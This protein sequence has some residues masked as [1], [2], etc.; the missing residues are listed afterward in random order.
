MSVLAMKHVILSLI[1]QGY[2][3]RGLYAALFGVLIVLLLLLAV[4]D[5]N[6][7]PLKGKQRWNVSVNYSKELAARAVDSNLKTR[8]SSYAPMT[9]G[10]FFQVD[11]G[12]P[13]TMNGLLLQVDQHEKKGQPSRWTLKGSLNGKDWYTLETRPGLT[14]RGMLVMPFKAVQA[15]YIQ[16]VQTSI[17]AIPSPW[18][19]YE[20]DIL[21]PVVPWQFSRA[22]FLNV[23]VG[24]TLLILAMVLF[25]GRQRSMALVI[26]MIAILLLGW[27]VRVYGVSAYE[28]SEHERRF[29]QRLA[30]DRYTHG[31][32]LGTYVTTFGSGAYWLYF[33]LVRL[34]YQFWQSPLAAFRV[35]SGMFSLGSIL[36]V[37]WVWD[38]FSQEKS[39]LLEAALLSALLAVSGWQVYLSRTGD[40]SG[41][42]LL[43]FLLYLLLAYAFLYKRG[44]V[45]LAVGLALLLCL[46]LFLHPVMGLAPIG[47]LLFGVWHLW[48][49]RYAPTFF[50]SPQ[51]QSFLFRHHAPRVAIYFLSALP[52]LVYWIVSLRYRFFHAPLSLEDL[53]R[54]LQNDFRQLLQAGGIKGTAAWLFWGLVLLGLLS[55]LRGREHREWFLVGQIGSCM[56]LLTPFL[57]DEQHA[58]AFS[59]LLLLLLWLPAVRGLLVTMAFLSV[60]Q[61]ARASLQIRFVLLTVILG[62]SLFFSVSSL[63]SDSSS[64]AGEMGRF[65]IY[66]QSR[67]LEPL[68]QQVMSDPV[69][70]HRSVMVEAQLVAAYKAEYDFEASVMRL[71]DLLRFAKQGIFYSYAFVSVDELER[72]PDRERFFGRHYVEAG[73]TSHVVFYRLRDEFCGL[74]ERYYARDLIAATGRN[75]KDELV[76]QRAVRVATSDDRPGQMV[77]GPFTRQCEAGDYV[78]RFRLRAMSLPERT[79]ATLKVLADRHEVFGVRELSG[80][81]FPDTDAY[82][83]FD[84][85]FYLDFAG[86]PAY[87]MKRL[88]FLVDFH[89]EAEVRFDL[90]ELIPAQRGVR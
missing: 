78:A 53:R 26:G 86:N 75:M 88:E 65:A 32:W 43:V 56:L 7:R 59:L 4:N 50:S 28:F 14:Y 64:E 6:W 9:S 2:F 8:W 51:V 23:I 10:M 84:I 87:Q 31:E 44:S 1:K 66:R 12:K 55:I 52:G 5:K 70:C 13:V 76:P 60:R 39:A 41:S 24:W 74:P 67:S 90:I 20:L 19:I 80:S 54:F 61:G 68:L 83:E 42:F 62:Y 81:D 37:F 40:F 47:L 16:V 48:L 38:F 45:W 29:F 30:F 77:F 34:A 25:G 33:L 27:F 82:Y 46:G 21:Q 89:G 72:Y 73:R 36:T 58:S 11:V 22:A 17:S 49:C 63:F 57:F 85:P 18:L 35:V 69:E 3:R 79:V 15:R 71:A